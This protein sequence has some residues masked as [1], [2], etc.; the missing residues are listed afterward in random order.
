MTSAGHA[1]AHVARRR[2]GRCYEICQSGGCYEICQSGSCIYSWEC[3]LGHPAGEGVAPVNSKLLPSLSELREGNV[4]H[5]AMLKEILK[6]NLLLILTP[7]LDKPRL[8]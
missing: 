3:L 4:Q 6:K 2:S 5:H 8:L 1:V 7:F